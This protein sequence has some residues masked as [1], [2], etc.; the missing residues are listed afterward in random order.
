MTYITLIS[1]AELAE[2]LDDDNWVMVDCRFVLTNTEQG[3]REY[4]QGHIAGAVYAHLDE[5]LSGPIIPGKTGRH[6]LPTPEEFA[7]TLSNWGIDNNSQVVA[8]DA[9][10]GS[11]AARLWWLLRWLGHEA[12]AVL[13]GGWPRWRSEGRPMRSGVE[14]NEPRS[15]SPR[16]R[17][18]LI[19][20]ANQVNQ[21]RADPAYRLFDARSADR[22]RGE[23]E[24]L[25]PVAGHIPGAQPL[26]FAGNLGEGGAF[27][28]VEEL[29]RRFKAALGDTPAEQTVFYCGSG[30]TAAHN[31]L[32]LLHA[33][34]GEA[35]LY[36]GSWS[37]W[38]TEPNR[39][40]A[41]GEE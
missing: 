10:G 6:P 39:P 9:T 32:A 18:E 33:G 11:I 24:T 38:I 30:V 25:D 23:N 1:G 15:F 40:V 3:R 21:I 19:L 26:P 28:P 27:L 16:P 35:R 13:D 5:D 8:Y 34:L 37:D 31:V 41:T 29:A 36:S 12:V 20:D 22:Y 4:E 2:H 17:P 14:S 7:R